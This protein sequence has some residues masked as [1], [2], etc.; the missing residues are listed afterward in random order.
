MTNDRIPAATVLIIALLIA[1]LG[2]SSY[3]AFRPQTTSA[4]DASKESAAAEVDAQEADKLAESILPLYNQKNISAL[5]ERFDQLAK[6]QF[7]QEQLTAQI[8]KLHSLLGRIERCA[9]SHATVA[10]TQGGRIFYTLHYKVS[11]AGGPLPMGDMTLTVTRN[12]ESL[13]LYGFFV[14][15]STGPRPQ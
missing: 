11:L 5:Y 15:G 8:E 4:V 3:I 13:G 2:L 12:A 14:N 7:T 10:G 6:V 1:N 9:Y